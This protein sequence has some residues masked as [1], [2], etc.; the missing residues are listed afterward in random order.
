[1]QSRVETM[2]GLEELSLRYAHFILPVHFDLS[3]QTLEYQDTVL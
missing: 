2:D 1:M 3:K